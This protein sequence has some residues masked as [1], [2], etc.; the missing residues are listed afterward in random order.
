[1]VPMYLIMYSQA[2][3]AI[4]APADQPLKRFE[5][6]FDSRARITAVAAV[7]KKERRRT[8]SLDSLGESVLDS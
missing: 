8:A 3:R 7:L 4:P 6:I 5:M 1:M 2:S